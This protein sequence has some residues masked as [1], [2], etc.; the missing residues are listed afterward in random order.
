MNPAL[1]AKECLGSFLLRQGRCKALARIQDSRQDS[2][3]TTIQLLMQSAQGIPLRLCTLHQPAMGAA[4]SGTPLGDVTLELRPPQQEAHFIIGGSSELALQPGLEPLRKGGGGQEAQPHPGPGGS[5][6]RGLQANEGEG[7]RAVVARRHLAHGAG[8]DPG[9]EGWGDIEA[10]QT[11]GTARGNI[12]EGA[13]VGVPRPPGIDKAWQCLLP[14]PLRRHIRVGGTSGM[15]Q[16]IPA[17]Q[18]HKGK[19][20]APQQLPPRSAGGGGERGEMGGDV[21]PLGSGI[22]RGQVD[23]TEVEMVAAPAHGQGSKAALRS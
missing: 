18:R 7:D 2:L 19:V 12:G 10:V 20:A 4:Q 3:I 13:A 16:A 1:A 9:Q 14:A 21:L 8:G 15:A 11:G 17:R 23:A 22:G 5:K 6:G